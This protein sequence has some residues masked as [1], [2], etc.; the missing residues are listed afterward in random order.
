MIY[1]RSKEYYETKSLQTNNVF[2]FK[3]GSLFQIHLDKENTCKNITF[4]KTNAKHKHIN[5]RINRKISG[6]NSI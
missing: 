1:N 3:N 5:D 4:W 2:T 6:C